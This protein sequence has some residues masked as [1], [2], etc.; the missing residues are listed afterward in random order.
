MAK[1]E[2]KEKKAPSVLCCYVGDKLD[3]VTHKSMVR[4]R[5]WLTREKGFVDDEGISTVYMISKQGAY[6]HSNRTA[7]FI[8]NEVVQS[9]TSKTPPLAGYPDYIQNVDLIF[10]FDWD[11][12]WEPTDWW[13]LYE[14]ALEKAPCIM[15]GLY[16]RGGGAGRIDMPWSKIGDGSWEVVNNIP[17]GEDPIEVATTG[18]GF[19]MFTKEVLEKFPYPWY[20]RDIYDIHGARKGIYGEDVGFCLNAHDAGIKSYLHPG[21]VLSHYKRMRIHPKDAV[22]LRRTAM[23]EEMKRAEERRDA[24]RNARAGKAGRPEPQHA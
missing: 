6:I 11:M 23:I 21:V 24:Q 15:T 18:M 12:A 10:M 8:N 7:I 16:I 2:K 5:D 13:K 19:T 14:A 22:E 4:T 3:D 9:P 1:K 20:L 17:E